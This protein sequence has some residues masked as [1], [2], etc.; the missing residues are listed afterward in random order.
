MEGSRS[1][2]SALASPK[3]YSTHVCVGAF[4][5]KYTDII[6]LNG[7][8]FSPFVKILKSSSCSAFAERSGIENYL[9][10]WIYIHNIPTDQ[11]QQKVRAFYLRVKLNPDGKAFVLQSHCWSC[12]TTA[13]DLG[14]LHTSTKPPTTKGSP[15]FRGSS[16][17]S[18]AT[19]FTIFCQ[20]LDLC[21]FRSWSNT[22]VIS[23]DTILERIQ[24]ES[25]TDTSSPTAILFTS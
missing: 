15:P 20:V 17:L 8:C 21:L 10:A 12:G 18:P 9:H 7:S 2:P 13:N 24:C 19:T 1:R 3:Q 6:R 5:P 25:L 22:F 4:E 23:N 11:G 14:S 16:I